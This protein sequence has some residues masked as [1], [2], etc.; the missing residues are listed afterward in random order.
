MLSVLTTLSFHNGVLEEKDDI[1]FIDDL[2]RILRNPSSSRTCE[3]ALAMVARVCCLRSTGLGGVAT[4]AEMI[5]KWLKDSVLDG[6]ETQ[7]EYGT[8]KIRDIEA[9]MIDEI[10]VDVMKVLRFTPSKDFDDFVGVEAR[11]AEIKLLSQQSDDDVKILGIVDPAGIG[12]NEMPSLGGSDYYKCQLAYQKEL[13]SRIFDQ[14]DIKGTGKVIGIKLEARREVIQI[15]KSAFKGMKNLQLL[16]LDSENFYCKFL[17]ELIMIHSQL[18]KLWDGIKPLQRLWR[19]VLRESVYLKEIPDLTNATS[20][21]ELDLHECIHL[22]ELTSTIG[23]ATKL[24]RCILSSRGGP[25]QLEK[26]WDGIKPLQRLWRMVLRESVYLK[27]IPDLTNATSLEELDLHECIHLLELTSTIGNATKLK[28]CILSSRGGPR[29]RGKQNG[30]TVQYGSNQRD[31]PYICG[32]EERL[33]TFEDS[34]C[35][36][37]DFPEAKKPLSASLCFI[38]KFLIKLEGESLWCPTLE[39]EEESGRDEDE[40]DE[41]GNGDND[42]VEED[43]QDDVDK[44][45]EGEES[46]R[47]DDEKTRSTTNGCIGLPTENT[48]LADYLPLALKVFLRFR[49]KQNGITVQYGSNQRDMPYICGWEERLYT[50]EDSFCLDQ[51]FPEAEE[52]TFS[53]L[54]FHFKVS[55]KTGRFRGKQNGITVQYGSNQRDMPYICGWEERLYTFEDSFCLDQDFPEAEE[56]TFSELVFHFKVSY[57]NWKVKACGVQLLEDEEESGRDEDEDDEAGNGDNDE[58]EEDIQD[59]VDKTQEGEESRR[60][61]DEKTRSTTNGCIGLPTEN[62]KLADYLPLALKVFSE[63]ISDKDEQRRARI[64]IAST[65]NQSQ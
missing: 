33:Y 15:R 14:K 49:G 62:T 25:S 35:L 59:D 46:R 39:D 56:A 16:K 45:Q 48:K 63:V 6:E 50:F 30:I 58:V 43:I 47:D 31:M 40:D 42:E 55:Y 17:V 65:Q 37:Q 2:F 28:R 4:G 53:E 44:T 54:V 5:L 64:S 8:T 60:D 41:A 13:L 61:D 52:A 9:K 10:A 36:D 32:W 3:V 34:F 1:G 24:K 7:R 29:F 12:G 23:N 22:L 27:E 20:L 11:I 57:K 26:L 38:S 21:E 19:M 18:E 51:D